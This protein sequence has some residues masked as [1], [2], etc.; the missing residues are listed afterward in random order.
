MSVSN[1]KNPLND[2]KASSRLL[3]VNA[4]VF[5]QVLGV[6]GVRL[7]NYEILTFDMGEALRV[8]SF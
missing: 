6:L 5:K 2:L 3:S 4:L 8:L 7:L 1:L